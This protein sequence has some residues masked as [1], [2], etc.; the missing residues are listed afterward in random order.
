MTVRA[1]ADVTARGG[2]L[3][4]RASAS[5]AGWL[6]VTPALAASLVLFVGPLVLLFA[7]SLRG[8]AGG[9]RRV[10]GDSYY[11][12][13]TITTLRVAGTAT[14]ITV[15]IGYLTAYCI[16]RVLRS[17]WARRLVLLLLVAPM[18][19]SAVVR[20]FGWLALLGREGMVNDLARALGLT[21]DGFSLLYNETSVVIG[22][23]YILVPYAALTILP[24]FDA[25][26]GQLERAAADLGA[27]PLRRFARVTLPLTLPGVYAGGLMVFALAFTSYVTPA[28]LSGG[29]VTVLSML[30]YDQVL[31]TF[32]WATAAALA[33]VMLLLSTIAIAAYLRL[34][35]STRLQGVA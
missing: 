5:R 31:V 21:D 6:Q 27:A 10:F 13:T 19:I 9:Y 30:I 26:S 20:S 23:V 33:L 2:R 24:V 25:A 32:D 18:F 7:G 34:Q 17:S 35:R 14:V 29:R 28:V 22:L 1:S 4:T 11:L 8:D 16:V 12:D 3:R 15:A